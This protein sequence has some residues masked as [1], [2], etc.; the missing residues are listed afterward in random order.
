MTVKGLVVVVV[1]AI[2]LAAAAPAVE[3][4]TNILVTKGASK[5]GSSIISYTCDGR[6]HARLR[7]RE[8]QDHEAGAKLEMRSWG[9]E[10]RGE[11]PQAEHTYK[12]V[13]L[14]NEHQLAIAETTTTG[15]E[16]LQNPEG[17]MHYWDLMQL[18]LQRARTARE[19]IDVMTSFHSTVN[20]WPMRRPGPS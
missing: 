6:F 2:A 16:E 7:S 20:R 4:C 3:A 13:G 1:C 18:A 12:V 15:R 8:A 5:D 17:L 10:A 11:I 14:M 19:A 9:G